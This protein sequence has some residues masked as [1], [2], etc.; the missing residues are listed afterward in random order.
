MAE[1][2]IG[3]YMENIFMGDLSIPVHRAISLL[4]NINV[5]VFMMGEI[6]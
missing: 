5:S 1:L 3:V 4:P 6:K 2:R